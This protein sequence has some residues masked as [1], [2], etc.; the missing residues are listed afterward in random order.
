M[1]TNEPTIAAVLTPV[2][3]G[4]IAVLAVVGPGA[5]R[6]V[7]NVCR[8]R[9]GAAM[10][11]FDP[12]CPR[13]VRIEDGTRIIDDAIV[14]LID[15]DETPRVEL[16]V[17]GG[18]RIVNRVMAVIE[19]AGASIVSARELQDRCKAVGEI[20]RDVDRA[21]MVAGSRRMAMWLLKQRRMLP[22]F[23]ADWSRRHAA[24]IAAFRER[25]GIAIRLVRGLRI[26]L[27]GPPNAGKSTLANWLIGHG[28]MIVSDEA[29]TTRDWIDETAVIDGWPVTLT[30]TAGVRDAQ[31]AIETEAIR[32]GA[33]QARACDLVLVLVDATLAAEQQQRSL[34][35]TFAT[36]GGEIPSIVVCNKMDAVQS[37]NALDSTQV[38]IS[39][40]T[41]VGVDLL[42]RR[43]AVV[44]GLDRLEPISPTGFLPA[45]MEGHSESRCKRKDP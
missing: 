42:E 33:E 27:V 25:S 4:A 15:S 34:E 1:N 9:S 7:A 40:R 5:A 29:G 32:R 24:E 10:S 12:N 3:P 36:I 35:V 31:C 11:A 17:H 19:A 39:A 44:V 2:A 26:G 30:D 16:C 43:I 13:L 18:V 20:E 6:V 21:L 23:L 28:R 41:G 45:H 14:T 8:S 37:V 38:A 22:A